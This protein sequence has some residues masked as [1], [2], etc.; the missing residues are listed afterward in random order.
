M[1]LGRGEELDSTSVVALSLSRSLFLHPTKGRRQRLSGCSQT[2]GGEVV[3]A[4]SPTFHPTAT[5][6]VEKAQRGGSGSLAAQRLRWWPGGPAAA[7]GLSAAQEGRWC[8]NGPEGRPSNGCG[9]RRHAAAEG[10]GM[11]RWKGG[12]MRQ[13]KGRGMRRREGGG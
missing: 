4:P 7:A 9:W 11:R 8:H 6:V 1:Q 2:V 12:D 5:A 10:R 13:Q 3:A